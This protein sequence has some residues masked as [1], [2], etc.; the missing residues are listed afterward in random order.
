MDSIVEH[1]GIKR[2][3]S[4]AAVC[5][6]YPDA[7]T[8]ETHKYLTLPSFC[9]NI[10]IVLFRILILVQKTFRTAIS[11]HQVIIS[12]SVWYGKPE[13]MRNPASIQSRVTV[14]PAFEWRF[15]RGPIVARFYVLIV[16]WAG[17]GLTQP[18][19]NLVPLSASR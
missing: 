18:A 8:A 14:G 6:I 5:A 17:I 19:S 9:V 2:Y 7:Q 16:K 12:I 1:F 4:V 13:N 15:A 10:L 11:A 3:R